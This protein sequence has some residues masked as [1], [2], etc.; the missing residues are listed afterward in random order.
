[1]TAWAESEY[2]LLRAQWA[3][4]FS[5]LQIAALLP[6]R[7]RNS[8]I[9]AAARL[10]LERRGSGAW[11]SKRKLY[12]MDGVTPRTVPA[13]P[14]RDKTPHRPRQA[15]RSSLTGALNLTAPDKAAPPSVPVLTTV[16]VMAARPCTLMELDRGMCRWPL[17]GALYCGA[18]AEKTYCAGHAMKAGAGYGRRLTA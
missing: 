17:D 10:K 4:G 15:L 16:E 18:P 8:I 2:D 7:S 5:A 1:M 6:G 12:K 11:S 3:E 13:R 14:H 9:G